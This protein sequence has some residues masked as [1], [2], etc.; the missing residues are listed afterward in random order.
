MRAWPNVDFGWICRRPFPAGPMFLRWWFPVW[1]LSDFLQEKDL[2]FFHVFQRIPINAATFVTQAEEGQVLCRR[3]GGGMVVEALMCFGWCRDIEV[4]FWFPLRGMAAFR[5]ATIDDPG[6]PRDISF[7]MT[8]S[9]QAEKPFGHLSVRQ[10]G[11]DD[12]PFILCF[13]LFFSMPSWRQLQIAVITMGTDLPM[14]CNERNDKYLRKI[15]VKSMDWCLTKV[16]KT[17]RH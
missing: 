2:F 4:A 7:P 8:V 9:M 1:C 14:M 17:S 10:A 5:D 12:I 15:S 16:R 13:R 3:P 6:V 11:E